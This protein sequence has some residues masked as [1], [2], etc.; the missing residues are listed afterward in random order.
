[1]VN[2]FHA[3]CLPP[4]QVALDVVAGIPLGVSRGRTA[5]VPQGKSLW[6][7]LPYH[8]LAAR[9][10]SR[11]LAKASVDPDVCSKWEACFGS[12]LPQLRAAWKNSG[13]H[14]ESTIRSL[15]KKRKH[16]MS[17]FPRLVEGAV[18]AVHADESLA[19]HAVESLVVAPVVVAQQR[20]STSSS[21]GSRGD[22][23]TDNA[24]TTNADM[25]AKVGTKSRSFLGIR[26]SK[27]K[28]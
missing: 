4:P 23:I 19:V 17:Q 5:A 22:I 9:E 16:S 13:P 3:A 7:P 26:R 14:H 2:K 6:V 24:V 10:V 18:Q 27:F 28:F 21:S 1:M 20:T 15:E 25:D 12:A 8:P 11:S